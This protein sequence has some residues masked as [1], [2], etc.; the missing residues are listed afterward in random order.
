MNEKEVAEVRRT[1]RPGKTTASAV[2]GCYVNA[3]GTVIARF[4]RPLGPLGEDEAEKYL[5]LFR[6]ALSG[7]LNKNLLDIPF[8]AAQVSEGDAH[9]LLMTLRQSSLA[10][11]EARNRFFDT[12]A[13]AM[14]SEDNY[15]ILLLSAK[16]DVPRRRESDGPDSE[17]S[18]E[19]VYSFLSCAVC[20]VK[21]TGAALAYDP[22]D[23]LFRQRSGDSAI[24]APVAGFLFPAFD[25]RQS[26]L[27]N[28]LFYTR[29]PADAK[30]ELT[31]ALFGSRV[32]MT[33]PAQ[34]EA[35]REL[36]TGA[37]GEACDLRLVKALRGRILDAEEAHKERHERET[38]TISLPEMA[39][40]LSDSGIPEESVEAFNE[41]GSE[42]FG[43]G[44]ELYPKNILETRK[45]ELRTP[46]V[47][48]RATPAGVSAIE[49]RMIDG[50]KYILIEA[51]EDGTVELNGLPL[52]IL[53]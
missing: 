29:D 4:E 10:D 14:Q 19:E 5:S 25:G 1:L 17:R 20:P 6:R 2:Y 28:A 32:E 13:G 45:F 41:M 35:F 48:I 27:Y 47:V 52:T 40:Y 12:V 42:R 43:R 49:T 9:R 26:N 51:Q 46:E 11:E 22:D 34:G 37:L 21:D 7:T 3:A 38:L 16:Y 31:T 8:S 50:R 36:L 15:V 23:R 39:G 53:P 18:S 33:A 24:A 30:Q 44:A